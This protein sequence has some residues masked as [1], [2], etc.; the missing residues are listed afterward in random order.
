MSLSSHYS[1]HSSLHL[2]WKNIFFSKFEWNSVQYGHKRTKCTV[3]AIVW[4]F[5]CPKNVEKTYLLWI[6]IYSSKELRI[7]STA[8]MPFLRLCIQTHFSSLSLYISLVQPTLFFSFSNFGI[9]NFWSS[10]I[11]LI[12]LLNFFSFTHLQIV[13]LSFIMG[14]HILKP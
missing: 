8:L 14:G 13:S 11:L 3:F 9:F 12:F 4:N 10:F 1:N 6:V 5:F 2:L 7:Y